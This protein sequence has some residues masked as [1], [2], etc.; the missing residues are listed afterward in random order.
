M[1][2][3]IALL[4]VCSLLA[5]TTADNTIS[6]EDRKKATDFLMQ[7]KKGI[8]D[9]TQGLSAAQLAWKPAADRWSIEDCMKHI[10]QSETML[11]QMTSGGI[12][13]P[14]NPEKRA[15]L[16]FSDDDVIK[17]IEDRSTKV[18]T[19]APLEPQNTPFKTMEEA[20]TSFS[21]NRD[22]LVEYVNSTNE[23][24]RNHVAVL[25]VGSFDSYQMILF[26]G[27]HSNRHM[28]QMLE[29]KADPNFPKN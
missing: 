1:K 24:L 7:T 21:A 16:K 17:N 19:F 20:W 26:I 4:S 8:W 6:K 2:K 14:A 13:A 9:A 15:D 29:V 22:K 12:K 5:F 3:I 23:D 25:P 27:A 11:W 10:A 18:K 28:Q